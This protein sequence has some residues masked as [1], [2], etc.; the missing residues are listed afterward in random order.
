MRGNLKREQSFDSLFWDLKSASPK[1]DLM[2]NLDDLKRQPVPFASPGS[3]W[4]GKA[5]GILRP[6]DPLSMQPK[7]KLAKHKLLKKQQ[8]MFAFFP[9][10]NQQQQGLVTRDI[11]ARKAEIQAKLQSVNR[12]NSPAEN[13]SENDQVQG[14]KQVDVKD[15]SVCAIA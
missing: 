9:D 12:L 6:S 14:Q 10:H 2:S 4:D 5:R 3:V 11:E 15:S 7:P 8:S 13:P 1:H